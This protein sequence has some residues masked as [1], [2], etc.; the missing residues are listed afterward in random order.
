MLRKDKK[1]KEELKNENQNSVEV[2]A[3]VKVCDAGEICEH[4]TKANKQMNHL[5]EEDGAL[6]KELLDLLSDS[7]YTTTQIEEIERHLEELAID[8]SQTKDQVDSAFS[9][10]DDTAKE[11][12]TAKVGINEMV[13][14]MKI[15]RAHV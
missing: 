5:V 8:N 4:A 6:S 11:I 9:S 15:G 7:G 13:G 2:E 10:M 3:N 14:E 12:A 1:K